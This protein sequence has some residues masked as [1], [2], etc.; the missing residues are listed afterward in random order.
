MEGKKKTE[1][2]KKVISLGTAFAMAVGSFTLST[3]VMAVNAESSVE[4]LN[5]QELSKKVDKLSEE[6]MAPNGAQQEL[7]EAQGGG[8][9]P[10]QGK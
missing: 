4:V 10:G 1:L 5:Q 3:P 7:A 9:N 8:G 6:E 2:S